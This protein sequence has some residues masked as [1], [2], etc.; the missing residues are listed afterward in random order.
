M[1][2]TQLGLK[3]R[4]SA[5]GITH[6]QGPPVPISSWAWVKLLSFTSPPQWLPLPHRSQHIP[7]PGPASCSY[8][9]APV[10]EPWSVGSHLVPQRA[11]RR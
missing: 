11:K 6:H 7:P 1:V 9:H 10:E 2:S 5:L 8:T 4:P 3:S